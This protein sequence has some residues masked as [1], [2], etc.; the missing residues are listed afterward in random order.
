MQIQPLNPDYIINISLIWVKSKFPLVGKT[1]PI[2]GKNNSHWWEKEFPL[3]R[4]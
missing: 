1:I 3:M 4:I 2:G